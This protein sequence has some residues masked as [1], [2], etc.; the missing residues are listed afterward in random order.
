M[1]VDIIM[2][3]WHLALSGLVSSV[4]FLDFTVEG[5]IAIKRLTIARLQTFAIK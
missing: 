3:A 2:D 4:V 1:V 5:A